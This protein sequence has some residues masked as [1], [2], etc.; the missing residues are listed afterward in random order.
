MK[1]SGAKIPVLGAALS[2]AFL[3][4]VAFAPT[5][6]STASAQIGGDAAEVRQHAGRGGDLLRAAAEFIGITVEQLRT[7]MGTDKS[8]ADVAVA[9]GKTRDALITAL[10][11]AQSQRIA[12]IVD[13]KGFPQKPGPGKRLAA[14]VRADVFQVASAYLGISAEDLRTQLRSGKSLAEIAA[15]TPGKTKAGLVAA[16]VADETARID[17][18]VADGKLTAEQAARLKA[19][20]AERVGQMVERSMTASGSAPRSGRP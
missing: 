8:L 17:K 5:I 9:H 2:L 11:T 14:H 20:L 18:A 4:G 7:E 12:E 1:L 19:G 10:T 6:V 16:I 13:H 3:A 15:A